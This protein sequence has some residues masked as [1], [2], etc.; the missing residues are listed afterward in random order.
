MRQ[1]HVETVSNRSRL[2]VSVDWHLCCLARCVEC[3]LLSI[4]MVA[5]LAFIS[6]KNLFPHEAPELVF[7]FFVCLFVFIFSV[8]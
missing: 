5:S 1:P 6:R 4:A 2:V 7:F 8:V 3:R